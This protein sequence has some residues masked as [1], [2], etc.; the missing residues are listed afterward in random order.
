MIRRVAVSLSLLGLVTSAV[1]CSSDESSA[2]VT[3]GMAG[4]TS[5]PSSLP[6]VVTTVVDSTTSTSTSS[7]STTS[8][9][10]AVEGLDMSPFGLG[11]ALFGAEAEG[12]ISYVRAILGAPSA[13]SGWVDPYAIGAACPG[14]EVRFVEWRDL[15]LVFSDESFAGSGIRHFASFRYGPTMA[16]NIDPYGL[17]TTDGFGIGS[18]VSELLAEYPKGELYAGDEVIDPFF[19][20]DPALVAFL[21]D[22]K[23][24]GRAVSYLG[25]YGCG[26]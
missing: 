5:T 26:E 10:P 19:E 8:T 21:T 22:S 17:R 25:G 18:T 3:T 14:T 4:A 12:V 7:T 16:Q 24:G 15:S 13:D 9:I 20:I 23:P 2:P 6:G 1:A 11:D